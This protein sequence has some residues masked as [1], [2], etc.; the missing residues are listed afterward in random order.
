[1]IDTQ[2][3]R[4][5]VLSDTIPRWLWRHQAA[6][7]LLGLLCIL[8]Y[9]LLKRYLS[10][11]ALGDLQSEDKI[12]WG[13]VALFGSISAVLV[14]FMP[15]II[16]TSSRL[17]A[18][19]LISVTTVALLASYTWIK[20]L[21]W[22]SLDVA[23]DTVV[24]ASEAN[25]LG[26]LEFIDT[27]NDRGNPDPNDP[28]MDAAKVFDIIDRLG[29]R[30]VADDKWA[31][32]M[33]NSLGRPYMHPPLFF[34]VLGWWFQAFGDDRLSATIFMWLALAVFGVAFFMIVRRMT[35]P[36][37]ALFSS[38]LF[39]TIPTTFLS[40]W[41]PT[42][43]I[44]SALA[45][46]LGYWLVLRGLRSTSYV[47]VFSGGI[48]F[49]LSIMFRL[50]SLL[51]ALFIFIALLCMIISRYGTILRA[52][53]LYVIGCGAIP[54]LLLLL[55]YN[56]TLT[57][58]TGVVR[59]QI[60]YGH[61]SYEHTTPLLLRLPIIL[62]LGVPL[63]ILGFIALLR[64]RVNPQTDENTWLML[65]MFAAT[66]VLAYT[67]RLTSDFAR[68]TMGTNACILLSIAYT[69]RGC[70]WPKFSKAILVGVNLVFITLITVW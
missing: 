50:T 4:H 28:L 44:L 8:A 69:V 67:T 12:E 10:F 39:I 51:P 17:R 59:Q 14:I 11:R 3:L 13:A 54:V 1:V 7:S 38:F 66:V 53:P 61:Y 57:L 46:F 36:E 30:A 64:I 45:L 22:T 16:S 23:L 58:V 42:Y 5:S 9:Q 41:Y 49:G 47:S 29:L 27:Y 26:P 43:D 65:A 52:I 2:L 33:D 24:L 63:I 35:T 18:T 20:G 19:L 60:Y 68:V 6:I 56:P 21:A 55:G 34:I 25:R 48:M 32:R 62:Y 31:G 37:S 70:Q 40:A 15:K